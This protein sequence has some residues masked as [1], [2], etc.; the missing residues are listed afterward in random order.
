MIQELKKDILAVADKGKAILVAGYFKTYEGGYGA[1]DKFYGLTVPVS[2]K[3]AKK[4]K[5]LT[6]DKVAQLLAS[7]MHEERQIALLIL[8]DQFG[9]GNEEKKKEIYDFY[10][11][12]LEG[13]N[14]WDLIDGSADK[15]VGGYLLDKKDR[16]ILVKLAKSENIWHKRISIIATFAFIKEKKESVDTFTIAKILL[17]DK[18]DLIHKA[19]GWMLREVGKRVSQKDEEEFLKENYKN[20]PRTMLRYAIEKFPERKR[21][22]YLQGKI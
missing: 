9:S 6:L 14:N 13:I 12:H 18:H 3:I 4:Y 22:N 11:S 10:L 2:R 15:I 16:S 5:T 20:M 17:H 21:M 19:V 1:G 8:A 7:P